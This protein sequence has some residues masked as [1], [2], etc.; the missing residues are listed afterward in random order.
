[1]SPPAKK[2]VKKDE[3]NIFFAEI[4]TDITTPNLELN[5]T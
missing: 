2:T 4:V 5:V 1:M 3:S